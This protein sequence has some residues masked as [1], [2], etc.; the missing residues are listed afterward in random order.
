VVVLAAAFVMLSASSVAAR[1]ELTERESRLRSD[2]EARLVGLAE[3]C[4]QLDR[5]DLASLARGWIAPTWPGRQVLFVPA[6]SF[7]QSAADAPPVAEHFYRHW[8]TAREKQAAGLFDLAGDWLAAGE[9]VRAYRTLHEVLREDP[10]HGEARRVLEFH[11]TNEGWTAA[12]NAL[13][14][15]TGITTHPQ[16]GWRRGRY[17]IVESPHFRIA[18]DH[19]PAVGLEA[20]QKL[21]DFHVVW[22][23]LFFQFWSGGEALGDRMAGGNARFAPPRQHNVVLFRDRAE[24]QEQLTRIEPRIAVSNGYYDSSLRTAF[25]F[26][27]TAGDETAGSEI[28]AGV[29]RTWYHEV[30]HQLFQEA[31]DSI[32]AVGERWNCWLVEG[33]AVYLESLCDHVG[34][35]TV[36]GFDAQRLQFARYRA[37]RNAG[38]LPLAELVRLGRVELQQHPE[39]RTIYTQA[40]AYCHFMMDGRDGQFRQPL[41]ALLRAFY[42]GRDTTDSLVVLTGQSFDELERGLLEYLNVTDDDLSRLTQP[43]SLREL[44]LATTDVTDA[45]LRHLADC[46]QLVWLD[47]AATRITDDGI[48]ALQG[49]ERIER[50]ILDGTGISDAALGTIAD[51]MP[52]LRELELS[53]TGVGDAGV[54]HLARLKNLTSLDLT[55]TSVTDAAVPALGSLS[56]LESLDIRATAMTPAAAARLRQQLPDLELVGP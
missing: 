11:R 2:Y 26:V 4:D 44:S 6:A 13:R 38:G 17:W 27:E 36:G 5:P 41:V 22:R 24:Y 19:S 51:G 7:P 47:L 34:Y 37:V 14:R 53:R 23:Q 28:G 54:G 39:F 50:L 35:F 49:L 18:T 20:A 33:I 16:F 42:L 55:G 8:R 3:K 31:G 45:G 10:N 43:S 9:P 46:R 15:R 21:E 40:A 30:A 29:H 52:R 12:G 32:D 25:L 48:A 56:Q 1:D